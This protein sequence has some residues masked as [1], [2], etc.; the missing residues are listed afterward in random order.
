MNFLF[1][2]KKCDYKSTKFDQKMIISNLEKLLNLKI[3]Y[4]KYN[5]NSIDKSYFD[6]AKRLLP[7]SNY[8]GFS[9]TQGNEYRKKSWPLKNFINL[10]KNIL[11]KNKIPVFFI[12][13]KQID[14][15]NEIKSEVKSAIFPELKSSFSG[16]TLI[17]ALATRLEKTI[18]IDNGIMHMISLSNTPM[19]VLF[20]PTNSKK[21]A[22]NI[23]NIK[24]L[25]SKEM[26]N[27]DD[28]KKITKDDVSKFL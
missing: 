23:D 12:E 15:I 26:Y 22:P 2:T 24:I 21:F 20:G 3:P 5:I 28:I 7:N 13:K 4:K 10:S 18:S 19:I 8:I 9:V 1:C 14:L 16:P 6:E 27:S 25:D 17:T 11:K